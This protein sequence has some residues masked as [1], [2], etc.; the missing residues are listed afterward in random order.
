MTEVN[1]I[2]TRGSRGRAPKRVWPG[3]ATTGWYAL[4]LDLHAVASFLKFV[5][6]VKAV[7]APTHDGLLT[8]T[9]KQL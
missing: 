4:F 7:R 9:I 2:T 5:L 8:E 3:H 6:V 1:R